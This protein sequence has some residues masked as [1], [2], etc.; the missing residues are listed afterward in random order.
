MPNPKPHARCKPPHTPS[1]EVPVSN[2][3]HDAAQHGHASLPGAWMGAI[4]HFG[5]YRVKV[6]H[7]IVIL[8]SFTLING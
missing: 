1:D 7:L 8:Q 3:A 6:E 4:G 5:R 2:L